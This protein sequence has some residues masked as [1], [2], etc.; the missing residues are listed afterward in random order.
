MQKPLTALALTLGLGFGL[1]LHRDASAQDDPPTPLQAAMH[2]L[3]DGMKSMKPMLEAPAEHQDAMVETLHGMEAAALAA[4]QLPPDLP[5]GF[6]EGGAFRWRIDYQRKMLSLADALFEFELAVY[7][8]RAEEVQAAF[9]K[10]AEIKD[11]GHET[12][13]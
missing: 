12:F 8:G 4:I 1:A 9:A 10:C 13:K 2:T 7:R 5:L 3:M 6:P 11:G